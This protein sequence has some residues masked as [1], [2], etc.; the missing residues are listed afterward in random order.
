M[1]LS[2][3]L[4]RSLPN[5][6]IWSCDE[7]AWSTLSIK[8]LIPF[9]F[10]KATRLNRMMEYFVHTVQLYEK[11]ES[12]DNSGIRKYTFEVTFSLP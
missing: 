3:F 5:D 12:L 10:F 8:S 4:W 2:T 9:P 6:S 7:N 1:H 11:E